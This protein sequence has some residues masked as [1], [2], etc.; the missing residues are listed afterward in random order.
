MR[1]HRI[2]LG[3]NGASLDDIARLAAKHVESAT[4]LP[5]VGIWLK[6]WEQSAVV[7]IVEVAEE[8][9]ERIES[10]IPLIIADIKKDLHQALVLYLVSDATARVI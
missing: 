1:V 6:A 8:S 10:A 5:S 4:V 7:E 3:R 2:Y 9:R